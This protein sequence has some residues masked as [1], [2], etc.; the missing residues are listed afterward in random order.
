M[1]ALRRSAVL[2]GLVGLVLRA[3]A[4]LP[5]TGA[6]AGSLWDDLAIRDVRG[7]VWAPEELARRAVLVDFWATWCVPCRSERPLLRDLAARADADGGLVLGV[8]L[9]TGD[10]RTFR[11]ALPGLGALEPQLF[12]PRAFAS[13]IAR[14]FSVRA[15]PYPVLVLPGGESALV[16]L[17]ADT[18][19]LA[20]ELFAAGAGARARAGGA[21]GGSGP[22]ATSENDERERWL[23][24][25]LL[26]EVGFEERRARAEAAALAPHLPAELAARL[27]DRL[28]AAERGARG[29]GARAAADPV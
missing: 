24:A 3:A 25:F 23:S 10:L 19:H 2:V 16:D 15:L 21:D 1:T 20:F 17:P 29:E 9:E 14:R 18:L 27:R 7:R 5:A 13:P 8:A 6:D 11:R 22:P 4:P 12:E 26:G 28:R